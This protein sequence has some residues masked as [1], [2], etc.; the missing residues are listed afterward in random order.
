MRKTK[1]FAF[2]CALVLMLSMLSFAS[3]DSRLSMQ[4][5]GVA[6]NHIGNESRYY[7]LKNGKTAKFY[8]HADYMSSLYLYGMTSWDQSY[9]DIIFDCAGKVTATCSAKWVHIK[10]T[11]GGFILSYDSNSS[12]KNPP[13]GVPP[14]SSLKGKVKRERSVSVDSGERHGI[15]PRH[16]LVRP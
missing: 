4:M 2:L 7:T 9:S 10:K 12:L 11:K 14:F 5:K 13:A 16:V 6:E 1:V 3:A 8:V 15:C